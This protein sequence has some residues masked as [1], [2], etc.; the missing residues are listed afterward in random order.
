MTNLL[1]IDG[2]ELLQEILI[3]IRMQ[4]FHTLSEAGHQL[5]ALGNVCEKNKNKNKNEG[6]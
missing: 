4:D 5:Q 3:L 1:Y 6:T 2:K